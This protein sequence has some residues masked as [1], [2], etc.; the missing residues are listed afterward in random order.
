MLTINYLGVANSIIDK[1]YF[2]LGAT[3]IFASQ[4]TNN[5][6]LNCTSFNVNPFY[7]FNLKNNICNYSARLNY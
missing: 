4:L 3:N 2:S 6:I 1:T 5:T 7:I